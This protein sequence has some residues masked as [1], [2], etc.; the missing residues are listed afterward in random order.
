MKMP[1][2]AAKQVL[3]DLAETGCEAC[4]PVALRDVLPPKLKL[5]AAVRE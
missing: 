1:H 3:G 2:R 4:I 5:G